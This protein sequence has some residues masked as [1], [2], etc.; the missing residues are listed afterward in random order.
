MLKYNYFIIFI[1][2]Y[3]INCFYDKKVKVDSNGKFKISQV[4]FYN[5]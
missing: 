1:L 3:S 4:G 2:F 5:I